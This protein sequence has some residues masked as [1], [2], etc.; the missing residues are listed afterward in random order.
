VRGSSWSAW[1]AHTYGASLT[2]VTEQFGPSLQFAEMTTLTVGALR[3]WMEHCAAEGMR[4][5]VLDHLGRTQ[6]EAE[7]YAG[8]KRAMQR[9]AEMT[10][11]LDLLTLSLAQVNR[12]GRA[13]DVLTQHHCPE[14]HYVEGGGYNEHEQS[15]ALGLWQPIR[16]RMTDET[17][18]EYDK[19]LRAVRAKQADKAQ[20]LEVGTTAVELLKHRAPPPT[21]RVGS[22]AKLDYVEGRLFDRAPDLGDTA[23]THGIHT[24][25]S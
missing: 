23:R 13:G 21:A 11:E 15:I 8:S 5:V 7:G 25:A 22:K 6:G 2:S 4:C 24:R 20:V 10:L 14:L 3:R 18:D 17:P 9:I 12:A 19:L 1:A 16:E